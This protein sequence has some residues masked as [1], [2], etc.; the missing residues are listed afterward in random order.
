MLVELVRQQS[1]KKFLDGYL[2]RELVQANG[3]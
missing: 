2:C 1:L 3:P